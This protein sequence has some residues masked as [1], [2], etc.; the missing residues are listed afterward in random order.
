MAKKKLLP[1]PDMIHKNMGKIEQ[2]SGKIGQPVAWLMCWLTVNQKSSDRQLN[3]L[4]E[5]MLF[6]S[7]AW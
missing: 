5:A 3:L 7:N 2:L 1:I 4:I 6:T